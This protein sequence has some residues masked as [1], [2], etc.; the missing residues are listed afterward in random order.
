M[1]ASLIIVLALH[2]GVAKQQLDTT[3]MVHVPGRTFLMG[4]VGVEDPENEKPQH[5]VRVVDF[6]MDSTEVTNA[7][8]ETFVKATGYV[9]VAERP[10]SWEQIRLQ[11]PPGTPKPPDSLLQPGS[12]VFTMPRAGTS[13]DDVAQW[14]KWMIGANWRHPEG[15]GSDILTRMNHPVVHIAYEDAQA[16]AAWAGKRLPTEAE[17]ECAALAGATS[18]RYTWG[19][20]SPTDTDSIANIWQ[21][22]FPY[23]NTERDGYLRTA[24]I[25]SYK[26]NALGLY[27][28]A[29][30]VWEWCSDQF[31]ADA[32]EQRIERHPNAVIHNPQ[33][34]TTSWDP[35]DGV[36][37][38]RKHV[39]RGG[40]FLCHASYCESYRVS[41]RRGETPDTGMSHLGF[42][43]VR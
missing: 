36:P 27:D 43:C 41:A 16:Y 13:T 35:N 7:Q 42:R 20:N 37:S 30:N 15:P 1:I 12:L 33:G 3:S 40:S 31:R 26:P 10:V 25:R 39:I 2:G 4:S 11:V 17:W 18:A 22:T 34:P 21:G 38:T 6:W 24:P 14:W 8:Y 29:G 9:T 28:M 5:R 19:N 32:Y 23:L